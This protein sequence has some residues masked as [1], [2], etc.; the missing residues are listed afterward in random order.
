MRVTK[1]QGVDPNVATLKEDLCYPV[2]RPVV[3]LD[4]CRSPS[5]RNTRAAWDR[6]ASPAGCVPVL[7]PGS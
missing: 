7:G 6:L 5:V 2:T 4:F 1:L 3:A